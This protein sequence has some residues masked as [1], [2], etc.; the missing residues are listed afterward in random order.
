MVHRR[1]GESLYKLAV[2]QEKPELTAELLQAYEHFNLGEHAYPS[3]ALLPTV[4][5]AC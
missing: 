5:G 2:A 3:S 4:V 1:L